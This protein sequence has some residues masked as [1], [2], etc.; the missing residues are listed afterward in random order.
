[1]SPKGAAILTDPHP[2]GHVIYPYTDE[3][4]VGQA[5]CLYASAGLRNIE[6]VILIMTAAHCDPIIGRLATEGF[7]VAALQ[8]TGQLTCIVAEELLPGF[9][10]DGMPD[11]HVFKTIAGRLIETARASTGKGSHGHVRVFGEMVSLLWN[12]NLPAA[13]RLE[14]L[15]NEMIELHSISLLCTYS[16]SGESPGCLPERLVTA[17]SHNIALTEVS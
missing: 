6:G 5:V 10:V 14:E 7:D 3:N 17:H 1:M 4:L 9:M 2:G 11:G 12:T 16:L 8:K 15:W 13:A